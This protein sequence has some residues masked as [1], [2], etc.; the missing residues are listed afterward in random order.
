[1]KLNPADVRAR[2]NLSFTFSQKH[3][4]K[5]ALRAIGEGLALDK[6]GE[7]RERLSQKQSEILNDLR[8]RQEEKSRCLA[9]R[10]GAASREKLPDSG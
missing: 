7:Y 2:Y 10:F 3:N 8:K 9:G 1:M 6:N 4:Q 5:S